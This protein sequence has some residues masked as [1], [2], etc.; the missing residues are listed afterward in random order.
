MGNAENNSGH[1]DKQLH[2]M[3]LTAEIVSSLIDSAD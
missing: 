1:R 2:V 3:D